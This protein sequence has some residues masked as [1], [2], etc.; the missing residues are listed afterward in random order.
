MY[1]E[2]RSQALSIERAA[3]GIPEPSADAPVWGLLMEMGFPNGTAALFTLV[4][5]TTSLYYSSGGGV[6]GR[7]SHESVR[8]ANAALLAEA[9]R[10]VAHMR[11]A[12]SYPR[13]AAGSTAFYARTD[14][15]VLVG[16][17]ADDDL[18]RGQHKL[19]PLFLAGHGVL[20][21]LRLV[22]EEGG[23]RP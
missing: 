11:P 4:D 10:V 19:S 8:R 9:N 1:E 13:P 3:C 18:G 7:Q 5:G 21:E 12:S 15:G 16:G 22:S 20:T 14:S 2:L 17:G 6:I 23:P